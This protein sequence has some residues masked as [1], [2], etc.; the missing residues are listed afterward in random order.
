MAA[1]RTGH[2]AS[3]TQHRFEDEVSSGASVSVP[4]IASEQRGCQRRTPH[5]IASQVLA[6]SLPPLLCFLPSEGFSCT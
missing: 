5:R 3:Q 6:R 1:F 4:S 2:P